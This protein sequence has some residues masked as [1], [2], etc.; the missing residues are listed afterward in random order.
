M[1]QYINQSD[2]C[3]FN[4][5]NKRFLSVRKYVT[6]L[7]KCTWCSQTGI[8]E[9][10][11]TSG[12]SHLKVLFR[13]SALAEAAGSCSGSG[14]EAAGRAAHGSVGQRPDR[15]PKSNLVGHFVYRHT[16]E[17]STGR[18]GEQAGLGHYEG[19]SDILTS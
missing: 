5:K 1:Y 2:S 9:S 13:Q 17:C 3:N 12:L 15:K 11:P 4:Q 6:V 7:K 10:L 18:F 8:L 14:S 19:A 16:K